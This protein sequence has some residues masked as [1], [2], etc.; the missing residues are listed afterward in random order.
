MSDAAEVAEAVPPTTEEPKEKS[1][2]K[3]DVAGNP[4][5]S[6]DELPESEATGDPDT[7]D[8]D[9]VCL[10]RLNDMSCVQHC[11]DNLNLFR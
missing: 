1:E 10:I 3:E 5:E 7:Q 8:V 9:A 6:T 11:A 2:A 4:E